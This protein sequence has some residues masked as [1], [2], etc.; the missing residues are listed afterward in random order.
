M[1]TSLRLAGALSLLVALAACSE[2]EEA[3]EAPPAPPAEMKAPEAPPVAEAPPAEPAAGAATS[4]GVPECDEYLATFEKI[5]TCDKLGPALDGMKASVQAQKDAFAGW[6]AFD[7]ATRAAA[8]SAAA[9]GCK[10]GTESLIQTAQSM[11][12]AL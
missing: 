2:K 9:P 6:A 3:V 10:S 11:G 4:T 1:N 7:D 5:A 12:C 8:H